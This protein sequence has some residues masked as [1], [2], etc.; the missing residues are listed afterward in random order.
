MKILKKITVA[1]FVF[2]ILLTIA[3]FQT[4]YAYHGVDEQSA[5]EL[6]ETDFIDLFDSNNNQFT[7]KKRLY[8]MA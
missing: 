5:I 2:L 7:S 6:T 1:L 4:V 8:A 3:T